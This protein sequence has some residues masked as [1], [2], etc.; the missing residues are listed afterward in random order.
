MKLLSKFV[1][2]FSTFLFTRL[3][4]VNKNISQSSHPGTAKQGAGPFRSIYCDNCAAGQ[5]CNSKDKSKNYTK[6]T[7]SGICGDNRF[8]KLLT[9]SGLNFSH[10]DD[11]VSSTWEN[12]FIPFKLLCAWKRS[13]HILRILGRHRLVL[14]GSCNTSILGR[15]AYVSSLQSLC[16][17]RP[18]ANR[19]ATLYN[20][21]FGRFPIGY[22]QGKWIQYQEH[23]PFRLQNMELKTKMTIS[24]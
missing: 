15:H 1:F 24:Y 14:I 18:E 22:I 23:G 12:L 13:G 20:Q 4:T 7:I 2:L 21:Q 6:L 17:R 16:R 5:S 3:R 10:L 9:M 8:F 11:A 19:N